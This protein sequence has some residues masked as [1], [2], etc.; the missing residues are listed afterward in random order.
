MIVNNVPQEQVKTQVSYTDVFYVRNLPFLLSVVKP[1]N[2]LIVT[3]IKGR[4]DKLKYKDAI[5]TPSNTRDFSLK[6]ILSMAKL[7]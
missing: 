6:R 2:L 1:L 5:P 3:E 7:D 4:K